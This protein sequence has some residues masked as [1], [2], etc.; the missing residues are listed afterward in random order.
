MK[1]Y[2]IQKV[3]LKN[4]AKKRKSNANLPHAKC[5][6]KGKP[7][8]FQLERARLSLRDH[9]KVNTFDSVGLE[10]GLRLGV[11]NKLLG[12]DAAGHWKAL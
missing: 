10:W 11:A 5:N 3:K 4:N 1:N 12:A 7:V 9:V 8:I 2:G 6:W